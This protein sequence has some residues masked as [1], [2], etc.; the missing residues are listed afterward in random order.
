MRGEHLVKDEDARCLR[1]G[2]YAMENLMMPA[3][4]EICGSKWG[5]VT[6]LDKTDMM[7]AKKEGQTCSSSIVS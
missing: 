3:Q 6:E 7:I 4:D 2:L 1:L 5:V